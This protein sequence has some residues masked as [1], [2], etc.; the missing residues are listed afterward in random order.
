MAQQLRNIVTSLEFFGS[1]NGHDLKSMYA[2][3]GNISPDCL[4][5]KK[6]RLKKQAVRKMKRLPDTRQPFFWQPAG[7]AAAI[8][9][10]AETEIFHVVESPYMWDFSLSHSALSNSFIPFNIHSVRMI[11][12][13][14]CS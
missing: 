10:F 13:A 1:L 6:Q 8:P 3:F 7:Y 12:S 5:L 11:R 2:I 9:C 14:A 4:K